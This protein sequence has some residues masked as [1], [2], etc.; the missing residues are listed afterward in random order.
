M[1]TDGE[2]YTGIM[3]FMIVSFKK[4]IPFVVKACP[5]YKVAGQWL[6]KRIEETLKILF[7]SSFKLGSLT[8]TQ[9]MCYH[10]RFFAVS[11][12]KRTISSVSI[13]WDIL[14]TI[15]TIVCI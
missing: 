11:R 8:I 2:L 10:F 6:S 1:Q 5:E 12:V 14:Y 13:S 4:S 3:V 9:Q 15:S 7:E